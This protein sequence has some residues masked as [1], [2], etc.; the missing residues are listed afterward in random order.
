LIRFWIFRREIQIVSDLAAGAGIVTR[1]LLL[2]T[3]GI[4]TIRC[5]AISNLRLDIIGIIRVFQG[6]A[7]VPN[8]FF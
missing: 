1:L 7:N 6:G 3:I 4:A 2:A 8:Q 5:R